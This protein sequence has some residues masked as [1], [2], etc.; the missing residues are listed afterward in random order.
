MPPS[1]GII[2][3]VAPILP[4]VTLELGSGGSVALPVILALGGA[5]FIGVAAFAIAACVYCRP[6]VAAEEERG[7]KRDRDLAVTLTI[8]QLSA[9][10]FASGR[11]AAGS[12]SLRSRQQ[13]A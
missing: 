2:T 13:L 4:I 6:D 10:A 11:S 9:V 3:F 7:S 8:E 5:L 1:A 12:D